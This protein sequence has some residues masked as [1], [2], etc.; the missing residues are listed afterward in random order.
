MK[1]IKQTLVSS[2]YKGY[3]AH[4]PAQTQKSK[5]ILPEKI[6]LYFWKMKL[7]SFSFKTFLIFFL[8][9]RKQNP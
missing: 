4:F 1:F 5:K 7:S 2:T 6:S 3:L 9:F 8:Y